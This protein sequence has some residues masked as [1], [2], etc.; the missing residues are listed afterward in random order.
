MIRREEE[1]RAAAPA[2]MKEMIAR[3]KPKFLI[4]YNI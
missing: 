2:K 1:G 4:K 3:V